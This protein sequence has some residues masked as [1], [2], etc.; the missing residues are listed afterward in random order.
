[1]QQQG[2]Q[3]HGQAVADPWVVRE[4]K[5][6]Q[7]LPVGMYLAAFKGVEDVALASGEQRWRWTWAVS[8]GQYQGQHATALTAKDISPTTLP[9]ILIAGLLGREPKPGENVKALVEQCVG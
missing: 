9:G 4:A 6:Y 7:P 5:Q 2:Q 8:S 1:E 3:Q